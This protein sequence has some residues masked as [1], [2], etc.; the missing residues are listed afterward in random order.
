M[1]IG[2][3]GTLEGMTKQQKSAFLKIMRKLKLTYDRIDL[4]IGNCPGSDKDAVEIIKENNLVKSIQYYPSKEEE[5]RGFDIENDFDFS[6]KKIIIKEI[7]TK[8]HFERNRIIIDGCEALIAVPKQAREEKD[9]ETW[10]AVR[11]CKIMKKRVFTI[12]PDGK[13]TKWPSK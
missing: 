9:S 7:D 1:K 11:Y 8:P 4:S 5:R 6:D 13:I 3:A 10:A 12:Y 2:F